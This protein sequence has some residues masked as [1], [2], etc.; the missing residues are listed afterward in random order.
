MAQSEQP[1]HRGGK[2]DRPSDLFD[3][4]PSPTRK[5]IKA[6]I[7]YRV[8]RRPPSPEEEPTTPQKPHPKSSATA[9]KADKTPDHTT[10]ALGLACNEYSHPFPIDVGDWMVRRHG[11]LECDGPFPVTELTADGSG[12]L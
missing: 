10:K 9:P 1:I 5:R 3:I 6:R 11:D 12:G 7:Q 4:P 2:A 8:A